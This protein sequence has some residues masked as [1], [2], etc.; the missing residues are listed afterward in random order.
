MQN[1]PGTVKVPGLTSTLYGLE[2][3]GEKRYVRNR[4]GQGII[5]VPDLIASTVF[6]ASSRV[7]TGTTTIVPLT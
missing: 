4:S 3:R 2:P 1:S 5:R 6:T 7:D